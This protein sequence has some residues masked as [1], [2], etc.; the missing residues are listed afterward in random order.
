MQPLR[1]YQIRAVSAVRSHWEANV[2]RVLLVLPTGAGK[3][4][5]GQELAEPFPRVLWLANRTELIRDA[6]ERMAA[7]FGMLEVGVMAP[8]FAPSPHSRVQVTT[9]QTLLARDAWPEADLVVFDEAAHFA[10]DRWSTVSEHYAT[11]KHLL[12]TATPERGDGKAMGEIADVLVH[13]ADYSE[14]LAAG[15]LCS[16]RVFRPEQI[17]G[18]ALACDPVEAWARHSEN[19]SG[20]AFFST[21]EQAEKAA[22]GMNERGIRAAVIHQG[23][24]RGDRVALIDALRAGD[25]DCVCNVY[26]MTE[27]TDVPR[28]RVCMLASACRHASNYLQKAG[29]VL[30]PHPSKQNAILIDLVG[31]SILHGLPT[32]DRVYSLDGDPIKRRDVVPLKNCLNCG[33]T[34]HAAYTACPEC[35]TAFVVERARKGPRI[36]SL[37]LVEVFAGLQTDPDVKRKAYAELRAKQRAEG[38]E[39]GWIQLQYKRAFVEDCVIHDATNDEK[40]AELAKLR[41]LAK[42]KGFKPKF[43]DVNFKRVFGHWPG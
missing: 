5:C 41:N 32:E 7:A 33:A 1:D 14:L 26:T 3:T 29:R 28:A 35:G 18:N 31:A 24:K 12:L 13:G 38:Y 20:F 10:A 25:L 4:R 36:F 23:T 30:R 39:L 6:S 16:V 43:A 21:I 9:V 19:S 17:L 42:S 34:V 11:A 2:R 37:E 22:H 8:G 27:G 15:H 40:R